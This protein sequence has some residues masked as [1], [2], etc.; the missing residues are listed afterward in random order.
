M[1]FFRKSD[2]D[3]SVSLEAGFE[4]GGFE[5]TADTGIKQIFY[6]LNTEGALTNAHFI[7]MTLDYVTRIR[8]AFDA[9]GMLD[10][11]FTMLDFYTMRRSHPDSPEYEVFRKPHSELTKPDRIFG[12]CHGIPVIERSVGDFK[13]AVN[14]FASAKWDY[15]RAVMNPIR[16]SHRFFRR[17]T[18]NEHLESLNLLIALT[19]NRIQDES[20]AAEYTEALENLFVVCRVSPGFWNGGADGIRRSLKVV[21]E[22]FFF[23]HGNPS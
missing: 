19:Y 9:Q 20:T 15:G 17:V 11:L 1:P 3:V 2:F 5:E 6:C 23:R 12:W 7:Q 18:F 16:F 14:Y 21:D 4:K 13:L 22:Q 8:W 10:K